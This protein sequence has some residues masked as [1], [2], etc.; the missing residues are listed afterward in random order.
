[1]ATL[2]LASERNRWKRGKERGGTAADGGT[3]FG[4]HRA[5]ACAKVAAALTG[6]DDGCSAEK[7]CEL[8]GRW[9]WS[10]RL[11]CSANEKERERQGLCSIGSVF[12]KEEKKEKVAAAVR[13]AD[14]GAVD[15]ERRRR[16][17]WRERGMLGLA[18]LIWCCE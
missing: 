4:R 7:I 15:E 8:E 18:P 10:L 14:G 5:R 11:L 9:W 16:S 1:M 2:T 12:K 17:S 13:V 3:D 6:G